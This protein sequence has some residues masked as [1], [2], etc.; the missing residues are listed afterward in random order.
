FSS[1]LFL[2][3]TFAFHPVEITAI[4]FNMSQA[5][6]RKFINPKKNSR[7]KE[8]F[9]QEKKKA[10]K[11]R[12]EFFEKKKKEEYAAREAKRTGKAPVKKT[13]EKTETGTTRETKLIETEM[14]LNKYLAHGGVCSRRDAA[15]LVKEEKVK[16][17]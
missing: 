13:S 10:K 6:F 11:E 16:V 7:I 12:A 9:R 1:A 2:F 17:N 8:E 5:P 15:A 14:P 4:P 3:S